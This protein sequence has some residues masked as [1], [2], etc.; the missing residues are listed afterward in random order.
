MI[1]NVFIAGL[2]KD[3]VG[4]RNHIRGGERSAV[5]EPDVRTEM[6][7]PVFAAGTLFPAFSNTALGHVIVVNRNKTVVNQIV[8]RKHIPFQ[9][10]KRTY[11]K[12][13]CALD[14]DRN[15]VSDIFSKR[16]INRNQQYQEKK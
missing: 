7:C 4:R 13:F 15:T 3:I 14:P 8:N 5:G 11:G 12:R 10:L 6:K 1:C 16:T 9:R 2:V